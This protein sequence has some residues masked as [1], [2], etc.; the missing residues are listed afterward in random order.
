MRLPLRPAIQIGSVPRRPWSSTTRNGQCFSMSLRSNSM[1]EAPPMFGMKL[2]CGLIAFIV[3]VPCDD[4]PVST[5]AA[6]RVPGL[7]DRVFGVGVLRQLVARGA[8]L[9]R[10]V[11]ASQ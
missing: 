5:D 6:P 11:Q 2:A 8:R 3:L 4:Q 1:S 10:S 9:K 7:P